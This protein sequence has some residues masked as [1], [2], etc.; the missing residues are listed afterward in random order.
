MPA[1]ESDQLLTRIQSDAAA[2]RPLLD[3]PDAETLS[4]PDILMQANEAPTHDPD[5][6]RAWQA[7]AAVAK[8]GSFAFYSD[9]LR[10]NRR[11]VAR[12]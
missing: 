9:W 6:D 10:N 11:P 4:V 1:Q 7:A 12:A 3:L 8:S 5:A 2:L